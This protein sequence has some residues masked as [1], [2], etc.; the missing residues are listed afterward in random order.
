MLTIGIIMLI[1][2]ATTLAAAVAY[3]SA[4][5]TLEDSRWSYDAH[6]DAHRL[7]ARSEIVAS[8]ALVMLAGSILFVILKALS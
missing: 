7:R 1:S 3:S 5:D 4:K 6:L 8:F 2:L